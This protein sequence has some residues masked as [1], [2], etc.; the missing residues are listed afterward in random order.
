MIF[1]EEHLWL[2]IE[3]GEDEITV[4]LSNYGAAEI[5]DAK[6]VELPEE[7]DVVSMDDPVVVI[8]AGSDAVDILSPLDGEIAEVNSRLIDAPEI[9]SEDPQGDGWLF[10]LSF[11]DPDALEEFMSEAAYQKYIR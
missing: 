1:T 2:R 3:D 9:I 6:F 11:D 8:E 4:G 10:K 7:G 5:G